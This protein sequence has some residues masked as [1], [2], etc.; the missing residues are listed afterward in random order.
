MLFTRTV[1][2]RMLSNHSGGRSQAMQLLSQAAYTHTFNTFL[3]ILMLSFQHFS[4][5]HTPLQTFRDDNKLN[6]HAFYELWFEARVDKRVA[7]DGEGA[8]GKQCQ[9]EGKL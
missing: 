5:A 6:D 8:A 2:T 3:R 7:P 9:G 4:R 1:R